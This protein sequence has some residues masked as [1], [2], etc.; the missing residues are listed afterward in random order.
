[1]VDLRI[2]KKYKNVIT[3]HINF[4]G[5]KD[6]IQKF[7]ALEIEHFYENLIKIGIMSVICNVAN[8]SFEVGM[9]LF[10]MLQADEKCKEVNFPSMQSMLPSSTRLGMSA[11]LPRTR[12]EMNEEFKTLVDGKER[13]DLKSREEVLKTPNKNSKAI[14]FDEV[15]SIKDARKII[16][17]Q[18]VVYMYHDQI[19]ARG[20]KLVTENEVFVACEEAIAE[21]Y[22][23]IK[24]F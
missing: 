10:E 8:T 4:F 11:S 24:R 7:F 16:K 23:M 17:G 14:R 3:Q 22:A 18:E 5:T 15:K 21:I 2:D 12:I 1:M 19:D 13:H 9:A 20:D 6:R